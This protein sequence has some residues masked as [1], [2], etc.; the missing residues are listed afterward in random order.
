MT[1]PERWANELGMDSATAVTT[2]LQE[3]FEHLSRFVLAG[4]MPLAGDVTAEAAA[5]YGEVRLLAGFLADA[6]DVLTRKE[7]HR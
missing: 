1:L 2:E 6:H 7:T 4:E 5:A 3:R